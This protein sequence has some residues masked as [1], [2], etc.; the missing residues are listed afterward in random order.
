MGIYIFFFLGM[1]AIKK[2]DIVNY[3]FL[4][5]KDITFEQAIEKIIK[6]HQQTHN[7]SKTLSDKQKKNL[8]SNFNSKWKKSHHIK[9][10]FLSKYKKWLNGNITLVTDNSDESEGEIQWINENNTCI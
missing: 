6:G 4:N 2:E 5:N 10:D 9:K 3:Y 8:M 7:H 1:A